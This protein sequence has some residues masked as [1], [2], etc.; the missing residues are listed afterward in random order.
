MSEC[1]TG[2]NSQSHA[3]DY[4]TRGRWVGSLG[5][6]AS[7]TCLPRGHDGFVVTWQ[8]LRLI[9]LSEIN[10]GPGVAALLLFCWWVQS[11]PDGAI[12]SMLI[13]WLIC[14]AG[15]YTVVIQ[16]SLAP[17]H[18]KTGCCVRGPKRSLAGLPARPQR[19]VICAVR[20]H[21]PWNMPFRHPAREHTQQA[22]CHAFAMVYLQSNPI[23]SYTMSICLHCVTGFQGGV[24]DWCM[25]FVITV[26]SEWF[27]SLRAHS[28]HSFPWSPPSPHPPPPNHGRCLSQP[29]PMAECLNTLR[30]VITL[31]G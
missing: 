24:S 20:L 14:Q 1:I 9:F 31:G 26:G 27:P 25:F 23:R 6:G 2:R 22:Q 3:G 10:V 16:C 30:T 21:V 7:Q 28:S 5:K 13:L 29:E 15:H 4:Q 8:I 17:I 19:A 18:W 12:N 11:T